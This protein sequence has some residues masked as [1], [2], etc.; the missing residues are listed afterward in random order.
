[1]KLKVHSLWPSSSSRKLVPVLKKLHLL[2]LLSSKIRN[3]LN[4]SLVGTMDKYIVIFIDCNTDQQLS[5]S[6]MIEL[7]NNKQAKC[8]AKKARC[9]PICYL[10]KFENMQKQILCFVPVVT[11]KTCIVVIN[12]MLQ[13]S[14]YHKGERKWKWICVIVYFIYFFKNLIHMGEW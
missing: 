5:W 13:D 1:M 6:N 11:V 2:Q 9:R 4:I 10:L 3:S 8:W 14:G 12:I 7:K